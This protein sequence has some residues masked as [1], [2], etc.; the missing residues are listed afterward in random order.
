MLRALGLLQAPG[1]FNLTNFVVRRPLEADAGAAYGGLLAASN[2]MWKARLGKKVDFRL[3][4]S[5]EQTLPESP[6]SNSR[7]VLVGHR[8]L[9]VN[10]PMQAR[11]AK[12]L[13]CVCS[14]LA[15]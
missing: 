6:S 10:H 12:Q 1:P 15:L 13:H 5:D 2:K 11:S 4:L 14:A 7:S 8:R 9:Q 3:A